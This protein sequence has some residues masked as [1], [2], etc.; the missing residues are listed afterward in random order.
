MVAPANPAAADD[1]MDWGEL[2]PDRRDAWKTLGWS[3]ASWNGDAAKPA[4]HTESFAKLPVDEAIAAI[5]LGFTEWSWDK[6]APLDPSVDQK[7]EWWDL[8][9]WKKEAWN[10]LGWDQSSWSGD[11]AK[12]DTS[13]VSFSDLTDDEKIAA[14]ELGYTADIWARESHDL[15][16][17]RRMRLF[18]VRGAS[19]KSR[20]PMVSPLNA[21]LLA[22]LPIS[23]IAAFLAGSNLQRS[24]RGTRVAQPVHAME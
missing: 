21:V 24:T 9:P 19:A 4:S 5:S 23:G 1:E 2:D 12:P 10:E 13:G 6:D 16:Y 7:I 15:G 8:P 22:L 20:T 11:S 14:A 18:S 3:A 17:T